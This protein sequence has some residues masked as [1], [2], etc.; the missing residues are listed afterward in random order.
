ML[1]TT[2]GG[3]SVLEKTF[4]EEVTLLKATAHKRRVCRADKTSRTTLDYEYLNQMEYDGRYFSWVDCHETVVDTKGNLVE[5]TKQVMELLTEHSKETMV[6]LWKIMIAFMT[7][8]TSKCL[9]LQK[10]ILIWELL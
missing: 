9:S 5:R 3:R 8:S 7:I 10:K 6:N 4:Q 1:T 2:P